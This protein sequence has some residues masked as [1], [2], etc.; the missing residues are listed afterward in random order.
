[1]SNPPV[2]LEELLRLNRE[3]TDLF[4]LEETTL[5]FLGTDFIPS[6]ETAQTAYW[7]EVA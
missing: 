3:Q 2:V 4:L 1:M 7:W 6:P 5:C